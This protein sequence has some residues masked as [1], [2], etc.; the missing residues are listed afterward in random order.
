VSSLIQTNNTELSNVFDRQTVVQQLRSLQVLETVHL[1]A[2]G[3]SHRM[4]WRAFK[5]RYHCLAPSSRLLKEDENVAGY[6]EVCF[7]WGT[8]IFISD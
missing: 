6:C 5:T 8:W 1:M 3:F 2:G 4:K 7:E